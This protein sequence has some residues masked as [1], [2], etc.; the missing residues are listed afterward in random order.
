MRPGLA[1][2]ALV[3]LIA[4]SSGAVAAL[5]PTEQV[6]GQSAASACAQLD[7]V[8]APPE[9][10][11][12]VGNPMQFTALVRC[13]GT[14]V[15]SASL[16]KWGVAAPANPIGY[17]QPPDG[18]ST[19][20]YPTA[21]GKGGVMANVTYSGQLA[22]GIARVNVTASGPVTCRSFTTSI[23]PPG[24][25]LAVGE[26]RAFAAEAWCEDQMGN[27]VNVTGN[28]SFDWAIQSAAIIGSLSNAQGQQTRFTASADG[29]GNLTLLANLS[30]QKAGDYVPI[31]VGAAAVCKNATAHIDPPAAAAQVAEPFPLR[32]Y[33]VCGSKDVSSSSNF[34]WKVVSGNATVNPVKGNT[35]FLTAGSPGSVSVSMEVAYTSELTSA[36]V[37]LNVVPPMLEAGIAPQSATLLVGESLDFTASAKRLPSGA[38]VPAN[39]T[40]RVMPGPTV[41]SIDQSGTF[42]A[43]APG[44]ATIEATATYLGGSDTATAKVTVEPAGPASIS[45][46]PQ[47]VTLEVGKKA[48]FTAS[49]A[50]GKGRPLSVQ[51]RWTRP[52]AIADEVSSTAG[53]LEI[54]ATAPGTGELVAAVDGAS[55][56]LQAR[57]S[58]AVTPS[59][60]FLLSGRV[61]D[62]SGAPIAGAKV[63][64][65][66]QTGAV[67]N[68]TETDSG[69]HFEMWL[70]RGEYTL[71]ITHPSYGE[72]TRGISPGQKSE[73]N[74]G[75]L[76]PVKPIGQ[77]SP[78][79]LPLVGL[80]AGVG[81]L[82]IL[83][84]AVV[85]EAAF[86]ALALL[87]VLFYT[88]LRREKMLDQFTR[89][90]IFG[91]VMANP[92]SSYRGIKRG[93]GLN[94][95][96]L[97]YHLYTLEREKFVRSRIDGVY[98]RFYPIDVR[99]PDDGG[100][101]VTPFQRRLWNLVNAEQG[102]SQA[103]AA[104][105]LGTKK[106]NIH[107][108]AKRLM[109]AG[110]IRIAK[111]NGRTMMYPGARAPAEQRQA[112]AQAVQAANRY[113]DAGSQAAVGG[114]VLAAPRPAAPAPP[115]PPHQ[116]E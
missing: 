31:S 40:W 83:F 46:S 114:S 7:A 66:D 55:G 86:F 59:P 28:A 16:I 49:V 27:K 4:A 17:V 58:L 90:Q 6:S 8:V 94:N 95:G 116:D 44:T 107:Y 62:G 53:T 77:G 54:L 97:T 9:A 21:E 89:G 30:G 42:T 85:S 56:E 25:S 111:T 80:G 108:N 101:E 92:G 10:N 47:S 38:S 48:N 37:V 70:P 75:A 87:P 73:V 93:L 74:V 41:G 68:S 15:T 43:S 35:T 29:S 67:V 81:A 63:E 19:K 102:I 115:P 51:V 82:L 24:A 26:F 112:A 71:R 78:G 33:A 64:A 2:L 39:F 3:A 50:D 84:L 109:R 100:E 22:Q 96:T 36:S 105:R 20:F 34:T 88:R 69:G 11:L 99:I 12:T 79:L 61:T 14:D 103:D 110:L 113:V 91:F 52:A 13:D 104:D 106:Q 72:I 57:A 76:I 5:A 45:L 60:F 65:L 32:G 98:K 18:T 23:A 1:A